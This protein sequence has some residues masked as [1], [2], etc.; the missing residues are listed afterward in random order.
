[1]RFL[2]GAGILSKVENDQMTVSHSHGNLAELIDRCQTVDRVR[3]LNHLDRLEAELVEDEDAPIATS[4]EK[5]VDGD[6]RGVHAAPLDVKCL[7][8]VGRLRAVHIHVVVLV[9][10]CEHVVSDSLDVLDLVAF[11]PMDISRRLVCL[12][13]V[14]ETP[15]LAQVSRSHHLVRVLLRSL[16]LAKHFQTAFVE[17]DRRRLG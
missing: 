8:R 1:M 9:V 12:V 5:L 15:H 6:D 4:D 2:L 3:C 17:H 16:N 14:F 7:Q 13:Q 11:N 10:D